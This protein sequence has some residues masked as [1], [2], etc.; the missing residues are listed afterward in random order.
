[1]SL[2]LDPGRPSGKPQHPSPL[3][4]GDYRFNRRYTRTVAVDPGINNL[5]SLVRATNGVDYDDKDDEMKEMPDIREISLKEELNQVQLPAKEKGRRLKQLDQP[6]T[7][8]NDQWKKKT[9][10]NLHHRLS[11]ATAQTP[12]RPTNNGRHSLRLHLP[13]S[14]LHPS[15]PIPCPSP[16]NLGR[17]P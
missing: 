14:R 17:L 7:Y 5:V 6:R 13:V 9:G 3:V 8:S 11:S 4:P 2:Y 1:M 16:R 15:L 12:S 10:I